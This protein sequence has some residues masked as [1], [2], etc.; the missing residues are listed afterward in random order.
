MRNVPNC[1]VG[2]CLVC[3]TAGIAR[4][5]A[6]CGTVQVTH[7]SCLGPPARRV[8]LG[9]HAPPRGASTHY[10]FYTIRT[11]FLYHTANTV[12]NELVECD[13]YVTHV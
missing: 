8:Y 11:F 6:S 2:K 12:S 13:T 9:R 1:S 4:R 10:T 7:A 3:S 5:S